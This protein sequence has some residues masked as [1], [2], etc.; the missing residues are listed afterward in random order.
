MKRALV[1]F[2]TG[3]LVTAVGARLRG[4]VVSQG[5]AGRPAVA[6]TFDDGPDVRWTPAI[7]DALA[8]GGAR[9]TFFCTGEAAARHPDIVRRAAA[10]GHE[11]AT[12]LWEHYRDIVYDDERFR[13]QLERSVDLLSR[14]AGR[15]VRHLRFP[16]GKRGRQRPARIPLRAVYWTVSGLDSRLAQSE[17]IVARLDAA[18]RPG[19]IALLHDAVADE[20]RIRPPYLKTRDATVRALPAILASLARRRLAAV[21]VDELLTGEPPAR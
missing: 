3:S 17:A 13:D 12:H 8:G 20:A 18:W 6:L 19:A 15:P 11:I 1:R 10:E 16:Y 14:L 7:L 4:G 9:A 2:A 5:P 21:T